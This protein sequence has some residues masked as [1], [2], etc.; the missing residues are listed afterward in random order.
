MNA[1]ALQQGRIDT[2]L[3]RL[4]QCGIVVFLVISAFDIHHYRVEHWQNFRADFETLAA[5]QFG[6]SF[7][8]WWLYAVAFPFVATNFAC[9]VLMLMGRRNLHW[10]YAISAIVMAVMP[11]VGWQTAIYRS[12]WPDTLTLLGYGI[13][14]MIF[15][16][17][18]FRLDSASQALMAPANRETQ[19]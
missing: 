7:D 3:R 14:G 5:S 15:A 12:V 18:F 13:G 10:P 1:K 9:M 6:Q 2:L 16:I 17:V 11:F 4:L 19:E 8:G